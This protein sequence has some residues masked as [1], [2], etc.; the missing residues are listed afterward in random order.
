MDH[1][2]FPTQ[3]DLRKWFEKNHNKAD[4]LW[5][6]YYKKATGIPSITWQQSV[7]EALCFGWIDG[8]RKSI[9]EKSYKIRFTPRR[10][11]SNWSAI[12]IKR[13]KELIKQDLVKTSGLEAFKKRD[14]KKA[15]LYS[16]E[17]EKI[18]LPK[19]LEEKIKANKKAWKFFQKLPPYA[20]RLSTFWV[21]SAKREETKLSRL[22]TLIKCSEEGKKIPPLIVSKK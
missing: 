3:S 21:I 17:Q 18:K 7:D 16:F 2:F 10:K 4:E 15:K 11:K 20:K 12:N 6:G 9:D 22:K 13:I 19:E 14:E 8:I 1:T 5:I